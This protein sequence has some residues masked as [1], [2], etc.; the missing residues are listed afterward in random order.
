MRQGLHFA[1]T[2]VYLLQ[3]LCNLLEAFPKALFERGLQLFIDHRTHLIQL[4]RVTRL[5][6]CNLLIQRFAHLGHTARI[7]L[8]HLG[9]AF[10]QRIAHVHLQR[11]QLIGKRFEL[12]VLGSDRL[13]HLL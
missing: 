10:G 2:L 13:R 8:I 7:A 4:G 6:L 5:E 11:T 12:R 1:Q 3:A 9:E